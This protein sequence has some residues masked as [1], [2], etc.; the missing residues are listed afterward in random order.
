MGTYNHQKIELY[1]LT[2][3]EADDLTYFPVWQ[4]L[5]TSS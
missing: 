5:L 1:I 3:F 4:N 2:V